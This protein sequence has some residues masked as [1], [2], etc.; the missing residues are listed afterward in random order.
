MRTVMNKYR[1][2]YG[3][4]V[5]RHAH[6]TGSTIPVDTTDLCS[7]LDLAEDAVRVPL[8]LDRERVLEDALRDA[9]GAIQHA[10]HPVASKWIPFL[11]AKLNTKSR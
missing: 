9:I 6:L 10:A 11:E 7:L 2:K 4:A 1:E 3:H 5:D 8:L